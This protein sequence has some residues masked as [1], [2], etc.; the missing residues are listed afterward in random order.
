MSMVSTRRSYGS[1][2]CRFARFKSAD[3]TSLWPVKLT[4]AIYE[5]NSSAISAIAVHRKSM[6]RAIA[7]TAPFSFKTFLRPLFVVTMFFKHSNMAKSTAAS[8][9]VH[10]LQW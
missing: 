8:R 2:R 6:H 10:G 3:S 5:H 1:S 7:S 9:F 4:H